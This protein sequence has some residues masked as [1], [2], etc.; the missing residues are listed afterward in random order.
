MVGGEW[1]R[2]GAVEEL[3][4]WIGVL[5]WLRGAGLARGEG[6]EGFRSG[7]RSACEGRSRVTGA[8]SEKE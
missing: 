3:R 2:V 6:G 7:E 4:L 1:D 5:Q 8:V